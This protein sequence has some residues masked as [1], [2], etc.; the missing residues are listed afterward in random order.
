[1]RVHEA[2]FIRMTNQAWHTGIEPKWQRTW[3][4]NNALEGQDSELDFFLVTSSVS[5]TVGTAT[6][7]NYCSANGFLDAFARWRR[8]QGKPA[9]SVGLWMLYE[10]GYLHENPE[11][12]A[13]LPRKG[14]HPLNEDEMLQMVDIA[15][16]IEAANDPK[17]K[18]ICSPV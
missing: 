5:G 11:I 3:N 1:M 4:L 10:V 18:H 15:L 7:S 8:S 12:E 16:T 14:I 6:E 9:V 17:K 2:L 13:L